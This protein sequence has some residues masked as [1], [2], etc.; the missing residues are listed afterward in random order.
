[1]PSCLFSI[2]HYNKA[3][4]LDPPRQRRPGG[5]GKSTLLTV[6]AKLFFI[7]MYVKCYPT[8][9]LAAVLYGV[10]RSQAHR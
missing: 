5:G 2:R 6:E 4:D 8:F 7:L 10:N 1:M 9:E 3:L